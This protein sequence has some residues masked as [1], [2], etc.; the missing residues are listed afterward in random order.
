VVPNLITLPSLPDYFYQR[1][2]RLP[3]WIA[4][5]SP[6]WR[7]KA[8]K[9]ELQMQVPIPKTSEPEVIGVPGP[10]FCRLLRR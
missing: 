2:S 5:L 7:F 9:R 1:V 8:R 4:E 3:F 6:K 10:V